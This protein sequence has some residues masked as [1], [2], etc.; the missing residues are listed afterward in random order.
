MYRCVAASIEGFIQQLAVSYVANGYWFYVTGVIPEHKDPAQTDRKIIEQYG[1]DLSK[2]TRARRKKA[3]LASVQ[4]LRFDRF[5]VIM[6][7][8]GEHPFY[9]AEAGQI[10]D[11]R[12]QPIQC[13]GYALGYRADRTG[14]SL[15]ASVRI[16]REAYRE[17]KARFEQVAVRWSPERL[18]H[19][20]RS[21]PFEPYAPVRDQLRCL[22][23]AVNRRRKAAGLELVSYDAIRR[24]RKSVS[25]FG[26]RT[27]TGEHARGEARLAPTAV[28][29]NSSCPTRV[30][31]QNPGL[32]PPLVGQE[33]YG[34]ALGFEAASRR[35][36]ARG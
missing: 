31:T 20:F 5:Y 33:L 19:A 6:A 1:L 11:V 34:P 35:V 17:L 2:W 32:D 4:Y 27:S 25:V 21:V 29:P 18:W 10:R 8:L 12:R 15:H 22:L 14:R 7:T 23:R 9:A 28:S 26:D 16:A 3:G 24:R 13:L 36:P 30:A